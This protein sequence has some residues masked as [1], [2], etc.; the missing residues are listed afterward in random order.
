MDFWKNIFAAIAKF[1]S[2]PAEL[3]VKAPEVAPKKPAPVV[4]AS[5]STKQRT[6]ADA[7]K[8]Y[9]AIDF[10]SKHWANQSKWMT[11]VKV[12]PSYSDK[13]FV[14]DSKQEVQSVYCN[15]DMAGPLQKALQSVHDKGLVHL[16]K[17][18]DGCFNIRMV[19]GGNS[20][21]AHAYGLAIDLNASENSLGKDHGG[22]FDHPE[23][24]KCFTDQG[25]DWGGN[26][27]SRKDAMHFSW[28]WE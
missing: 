16:L 8:R 1:F 22:F 11:S 17:S 23:F 14:G 9:G 25:F 19:R 7:V 4:P 12:D 26:F 24:V 21:S 3:V 20:A 18:Y 28:C 10:S 13:W 2:Q 6:R 5:T 27:K 15:K